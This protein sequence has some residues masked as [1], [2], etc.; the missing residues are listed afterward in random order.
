LYLLFSVYKENTR[1]IRV[2]SKPFV[3]LNIIYDMCIYTPY[4]KIKVGLTDSST[5]VT[6]SKEYAYT[7]STKSMLLK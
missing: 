2:V 7:G 1:K 5:S 6:M 3:E 4:F